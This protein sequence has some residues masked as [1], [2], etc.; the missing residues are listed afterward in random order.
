MIHVALSI[1][2]FTNTLTKEPPS[3][4]PQNC[5]QTGR[6]KSDFNQ[7]LKDID[8]NHRQA[9]FDDIIQINIVIKNM[10]SPNQYK[11]GTKPLIWASPACFL[12]ARI[13][14]EFVKSMPMV[15]IPP[16]VVEMELYSIS[17]FLKWTDN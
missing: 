17:K 1:L 15:Q 14:K 13:Y 16:C 11:L 3:L 7:L 9:E 5:V 4:G 2:I 12:K 8:P 10:L 6:F